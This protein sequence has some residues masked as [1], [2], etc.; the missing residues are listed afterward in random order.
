MKY[1]D[2]E[3]KGKAIMVW[4]S[5]HSFCDGVS[6]VLFNLAISKE[7]DRSFF[8]KSTD[9]TLWQRIFVRCCVPFQLFYVSYQFLK[10]FLEYVP[11]NMI[12]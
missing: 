11:V 7:F 9:L 1:N 4:K 3:G 10:S 6:M 8:V 2:P 5:H 12:T